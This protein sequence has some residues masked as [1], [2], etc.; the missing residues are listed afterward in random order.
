[1][2]PD[3]VPF[4]TKNQSWHWSLNSTQSWMQEQFFTKTNHQIWWFKLRDKKKCKGICFFGLWDGKISKFLPRMCFWVWKWAGTSSSN[5]C[6]VIV[7]APSK[8]PQYFVSGLVSSHFFT[9]EWFFTLSITF[10]SA[11]GSR[12]SG[13]AARILLLKSTKKISVKQTTIV[14][15]DS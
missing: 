14:I 10:L 15:Y 4:H 8:N 13:Y 3:F 9:L 12:M 6:S 7:L 2:L 5:R 11:S 1:M